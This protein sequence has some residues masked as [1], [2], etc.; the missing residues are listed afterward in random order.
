MIKSVMLSMS[1]VL[2]QCWS[3]HNTW[4]ASSVNLSAWKRSFGQLYPVLPSVS[5]TR[6]PR[7]N[8][9][10][11]PTSLEAILE[12]ANHDKE[13]DLA[14]LANLNTFAIDCFAS[15]GGCADN[16]HHCQVVVKMEAKRFGFAYFQ[17]SLHNS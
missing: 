7:I 8:Q 3:K 10:T 2:E 13:Q 14:I 11:I 9:V 16:G 15:D 17:I 4:K 1:S 12:A 6:W 5:L